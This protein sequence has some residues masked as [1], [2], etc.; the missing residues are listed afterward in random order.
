M[1]VSTRRLLVLWTTAVAMVVAAA[2]QVMVGTAAAAPSGPT[3]ESKVP[4]YFGPY[5]N[6]ANSPLTLSAAAVTITGTGSGAAAVAQ[7]DPVTGG[8]TSVSITAPG[9][10]YQADTAVTIGGSTG[11]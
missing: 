2:V 9:H 11:T 10:D 4:H 8:I 3:D 6:W 1:S 5:P 7:V